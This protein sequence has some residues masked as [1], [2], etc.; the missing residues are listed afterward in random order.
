MSEDGNVT[1]IHTVRNRTMSISDMLKIL[2]NHERLVHNSKLDQLLLDET[3]IKPKPDIPKIVAARAAGRKTAWK[4]KTAHQKQ[5]LASMF[6]Q[7]SLSLKRTEKK[8]NTK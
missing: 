5:Q 7:N 3:S 2:N 4:S 8:G 6:A 1:K